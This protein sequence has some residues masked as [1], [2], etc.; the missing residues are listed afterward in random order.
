MNDEKEQEEQAERPRPRIVDKRV[1]A[2]GAGGTGPPT[3]SASSPAPSKPVP[4]PSEPAPPSPPAEAPEATEPPPPS[5][6]PTSSPAP[7]EPAEAP[8]PGSDVWTPEQEAEAQQLAREIAERP[9][10][11]WVLNIAVTLANVAGAKLDLGVADDA[12]LAIDSLEAIVNGVGDRLGEA[13]A[14]LRQTLAQLQL[15]Y[16][17]T[18]TPPPSP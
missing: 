3:E 1:S 18:V 14:P 4:A 11:D 2:R 12:R 16:A 10:E 17:Q 15:A 6:D 7:A 13:N 9:S 8:S 5:A